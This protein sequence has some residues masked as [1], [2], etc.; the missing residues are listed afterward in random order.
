MTTENAPGASRPT[1][2]GKIALII[3]LALGAFLRLWNFPAAQEVR[4]WDEIGYTCDGLMAW[5]GLPPGWAS[6]T[7]A[8]PQ[9]WIGWF[10]AGGRSGLEFLKLRKDKTSPPLVKPYAAVDQALFK[11]Y[12]N[13]DGLR[14]VLLS[15]SFV[16]ALAG[17]Y[18]GYRLGVRYS[19]I[20]GGLL[21]GGLVAMLPLYIELCAIA[22][23]C[24]DAWM[25]GLLAIACAATTTGAK[26]CWLSG[27]FLGLAIGSRM[28]MLLTV[29]LVLWALWDSQQTGSFW[30]TILATMAVTL[31][32]FII[33]TPF[34]VESF[35]GLARTA[36]S[37]RLLGY[38]TS[39]SPRLDTL[40]DL[41]W[42]QGLGLALIPMII[43]VF[44]FPP[45]TRLKRAVLLAIVVLLLSTMFDG[46]YMVMRYHGGPILAL[47][48]CIAVAAGSLLRKM[49][50]KLAVPL[51]ALLLILPLAQ[52]V[53]A[54]ISTKATFVP[55][56][57]T[58]WIDGHVPAG[59]TV[60]L[61]PGFISRAVLP[62]EAAADA[63]WDLL[64][65]NHA[66]RT[67]MN[68]GFQRFS[69]PKGYLPRALSEDNLDQ[70]R[71]IARRWFILGGG[72]SSR[73]RF[74]VRLISLSATFGLQR[75]NTGAEFQRTG[76]VVVWRTAASGMPSGLGEPL[77]KWVNS[78]GDGTMIFV[79]P[80]IREKLK[81]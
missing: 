16:L 30:K 45:G 60:Y 3:V 75:S 48:F 58:E 80:D 67:R 15:F 27:A 29:P 63:I 78:N 36:V 72:R 54:V 61:H 1:A 32:A 2:N 14:F 79:S 4:D 37:A 25:F 44:L 22:K 5:E 24:S 56:N 6:T 65:E 64:T 35:V 76:G 31:G 12:E 70:D 77:I 21:L 49:P 55:E 11:S 10:Y 50:G 28:D 57:S 26:R 42:N 52:T 20:G 34:A 40:K 62:T 9:T 43:G 23:S 59:T 13:L 69:L 53:R 33:G 74:D 19:G 41:V 71:G 39:K 68:E 51:A 8:G 17:I 73:P 18:G 47:L 66:W 81:K 46:R 7:P 38:W